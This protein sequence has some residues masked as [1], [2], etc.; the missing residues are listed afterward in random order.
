MIVRLPRSFE[1]DSGSKSLLSGPSLTCAVTGYCYRSLI[2]EPTVHSV[3]VN[4]LDEMLS[5]PI[6]QQ[7]YRP[8][9]MIQ[10]VISDSSPRV[11]SQQLNRA[12]NVE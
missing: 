8:I 5:L 12:P 2:D 9:L 1:A 4:C 10:R 7:L 11:E 6:G 3:L